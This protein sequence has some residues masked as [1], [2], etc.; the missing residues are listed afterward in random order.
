MN[1][2]CSSQTRSAIFICCYNSIIHVNTIR[3]DCKMRCNSWSC[4]KHKV[5]IWLISSLWLPWQPSSQWF[6][7][8]DEV[9]QRN[10]LIS[11]CTIRDIQQMWVK[12]HQW[13]IT[14]GYN[15]T[16]CMSIHID[17][18]SQHFNPEYNTVWLQFQDTNILAAV[19]Y[20]DDSFRS[21]QIC[22]NTQHITWSNATCP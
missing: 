6:L 15:V 16:H 7:N 20:N 11:A 9:Q 18:L 8:A 1:S 12:R 19:F 21:C 3:F 14:Q 17:F 10:I 4:Q 2:H 22:Q 13:S 5:S